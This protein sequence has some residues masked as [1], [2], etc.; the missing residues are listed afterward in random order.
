MSESQVD[1]SHVEETVTQIFTHLVKDDDD[2]NQLSV[3]LLQ[4]QVKLNLG[5]ATGSYQKPLNQFPETVLTM[6]WYGMP[7]ATQ[8]STTRTGT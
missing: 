8:F 5:Y 1:A 2:E 6:V 4:E 3:E 7:Q